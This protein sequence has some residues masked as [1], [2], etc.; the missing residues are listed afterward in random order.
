[1]RRR[2]P[3]I[4]PLWLMTDERMGEGL[5]RALERLPRGSGVVL[6]HYGLATHVRR[7][8]AARVAAVARKR[9]LTL[10]IAGGGAGIRGA[11][12]HNA[13]Q[14][15]RLSLRT[16]SAHNRREAIA[17][18]RSRADAVFVSPIFPTRSHPGAGALGPVRF[19]LMV[20][21]LRVPIIALGGMN[22]GRGRRLRALG[23]SGWAAIDAWLD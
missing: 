5:W 19:G 9:G 15:A 20:R 4:P 10:V 3:P 2:H 21:G 17:A 22:A 11:G 23:S 1:M 12:I 13:R 8:L 7:Q 14:P 16:A 6:R 18:V